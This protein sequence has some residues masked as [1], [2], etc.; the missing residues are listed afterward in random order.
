MKIITNAE[1]TKGYQYWKEMFN[2]NESLRRDYGVNVIAYGHP[3]G[4]DNE[5]YT[6]IEVESMDKMQEM[7]QTPQMVKL[8]TEAGVNLD[9]QKFII[10]EN[11]N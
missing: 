4:N 8:R 11:G 3:Q 2:S 10:L 6:V 7:L 5:I 1:I 9:T